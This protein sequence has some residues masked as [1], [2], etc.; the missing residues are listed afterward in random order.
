M[1]TR[2]KM[3]RCRPAGDPS[4]ALSLHSA[5]AQRLLFN[6]PLF[7]KARRYY[8]HTHS[9]IHTYPPIPKPKP[10][11][12]SFSLRL[13][14][15][16]MRAP[17][18]HSIRCGA[19]ERAARWEIIH[20]HSLARS[21]PNNDC[22]LLDFWR[23][24]DARRNCALARTGRSFSSFSRRKKRQFALLYAADAPFKWE[25]ALGKNK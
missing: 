21:A 18:V 16:L 23:R 13:E 1:T 8:T 7:P 15:C 11:G 3:R 19:S 9:L 10:P 4:L 22:V 5:A 6:F 20:A 2:T 14:W 24:C 17:T 12:S 25:R